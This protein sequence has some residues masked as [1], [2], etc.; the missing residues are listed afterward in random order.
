MKKLIYFCSISIFLG[1]FLTLKAQETI[2]ELPE[3][4]IKRHA[5]YDYSHPLTNTDSIMD[6]ASKKMPLKITG[7]VYLS[8]KI[9][10]AK[11]VILYIEQTDEDGNF[12]LNKHEKKRFVEHRAW[13]KTNADGQYTF[14][15]FVPGAY[16]LSRDLKAIHLTIKE[17]DQ[18][19]YNSNNFIFDN[20][21][22]LTKSCRKRLAKR[23]VDRILTPVKEGKMLVARKDIVLNQYRV[24]V[25]KK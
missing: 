17:P 12:K 15:T 25:A 7:T 1:N 16:R 20:D 5:I 14:Y 2:Q 10:P 13:V 22:R 24:E 3:N 19:E 4:Y 23:G 21:H 11:D 8:D 9:T 18:V 6:F